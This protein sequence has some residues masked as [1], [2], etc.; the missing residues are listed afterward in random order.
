ML[1]LA[2]S[3]RQEALQQYEQAR[4]A[5]LGYGLTSL[6]CISAPVVA[7]TLWGDLLGVK[8]SVG[9]G[10][11]AFA[12]VVVG[13]INGWKFIIRNQDCKELEQLLALKAPPSIQG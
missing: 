3:S 6:L 4:R 8:R 13:L 2:K 7:M 12:C 11:M 5:R 10:L 9:G 1:K